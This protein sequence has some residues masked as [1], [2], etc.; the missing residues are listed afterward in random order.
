LAH[1]PK[2]K[3][4]RSCAGPEGWPKVGKYCVDTKVVR[5]PIHAHTARTPR[6]VGGHGQCGSELTCAG[7]SF[8][9]V[10]LPALARPSAESVAAGGL[11]LLFIDE[12]GA[13]E[14]HS[15]AFV[16]VVDERL[17]QCSATATV[18][19][20]V[21]AQKGAGL[22]AAV[23]ARRAPL[24]QPRTAAHSARGR[25]GVQARDDASLFTMS[26]ENRDGLESSVLCKL[27]GLLGLDDD[28][29][30]GWTLLLE[31]NPAAGGGAISVAAKKN[32]QRAKKKK[33]RA[34]AVRRCHLF[35]RVLSPTARTRGGWQ[36]AAAAVAA[37]AEL[38]GKAAVKPLEPG[39]PALVAPGEAG[40]DEA[41]RR[42][43][44]GRRRNYRPSWWR[45]GKR[46]RPRRWRS[47]TTGRRISAASPLTSE[48]SAAAPSRRSFAR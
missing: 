9:R 12:V 39:L 6:S 27:K 46:R 42:L 29:N 7:Q 14:L 15:E 11:E 48:S 32:A 24:R 44:R 8:E 13:M 38:K 21:V 5:P 18:A 1:R 25:C 28:V 31:A 45:S 36:A 10:A 40:T 19:V 23:K 20:A 30:G 33:E 37:P 17:R 47:R 35:L 16:E 3:V 22:I 34:E 43:V 4:W 2:I 41:G 26:V